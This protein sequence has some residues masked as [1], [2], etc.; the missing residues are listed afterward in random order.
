VLPSDF[1]VELLASCVVF[2][3]QNKRNFQQKNSELIS[4]KYP[5]VSLPRCGV[6][7][8]I[9]RTWYC[10]YSPPVSLSHYDLCSHWCH[11]HV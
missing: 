7:G 6:Q 11:A 2:S 9:Y 10:C 5:A 1:C 3:E 8:I 4:I